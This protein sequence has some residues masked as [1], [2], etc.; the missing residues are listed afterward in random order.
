M[1]AFQEIYRQAGTAIHEHKNSPVSDSPQNPPPNPNDGNVFQLILGSR[2]LPDKEKSHKRITEE[3]FDLLIPGGETTSRI[4]TTATYHI[5]ANK[6]RIL[7]R[8]KAELSSVLVDRDTRP[9]VKDLEKLPWLVSVA[10]HACHKLSTYIT[11]TATTV[12]DRHHQGI[13]TY[14][15]S[16]NLPPTTHIAH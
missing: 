5:L 8:L 3:A 1:N 13:S 14:H 4:L 12:T 16:G 9:D 15:R 10:V 7:P 11:E 6:D 2:T